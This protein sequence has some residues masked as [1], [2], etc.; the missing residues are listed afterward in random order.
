MA[1]RHEVREQF[2]ERRSEAC[3]SPRL[4][5]EDRRSQRPFITCVVAREGLEHVCPLCRRWCFDASPPDGVRVGCHGRSH[6]RGRC[7]GLARDATGSHRAGQ[8]TCKE[9]EESDV[10]LIVSYGL[11]NYAIR[12]RP[13]RYG[14]IGTLGR[15]ATVTLALTR[16][17][18]PTL[19][20]WRQRFVELA[21]APGSAK[22]KWLTEQGSRAT[23]TRST[24][25]VSRGRDARRTRHCARSWRSRRCWASSLKISSPTTSPICGVAEGRRFDPLATDGNDRLACGA[26]VAAAST[27]HGR[28]P[29]VP[30][31]AVPSDLAIRRELDAVG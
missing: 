7:T 24:R 31:R 25:R 2:R 22:S 23:P 4:R 21:R 18:L 16:S 8:H 12:N 14:S 17:G 28:F 15:W 1:V 26:A 3:A 29:D 27:R 13:Y 9:A 20:S 11:R 19:R 5:D 10:A 6:I 30:V